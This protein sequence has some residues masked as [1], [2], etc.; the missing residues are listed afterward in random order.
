MNGIN[1]NTF[2]ANAGLFQ[3]KKEKDVD[4]KQK[5]LFGNVKVPGQTV[6]KEEKNSIDRLQDG[7]DVIHGIFP[8][9]YGM[10][11]FQVILCKHDSFPFYLLIFKVPSAFRENRFRN[12][13]TMPAVRMSSAWGQRFA[14][15]SSYREA[16]SPSPA[17][18]RWCRN[19]SSPPS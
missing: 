7:S 17:N 6:S 1:M 11:H 15:S 8:A 13:Q 16:F 3:P 10:G 19:R 9:V 14:S 18:Q 4:G 5:S 12:C 2:F